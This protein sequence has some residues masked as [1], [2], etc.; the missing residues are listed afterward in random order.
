M[1]N[2]T[3]DVCPECKRPSVRWTRSLCH[4]CYMQ[5]WK[6]GTHT[7]LPKRERPP[8][9]TVE[10]PC[11]ICHVVKPLD[12]FG[13]NA[14]RSDGRGSY[15]RPCQREKYHLPAIQRR[16]LVAQHFDGSQTCRVCETDKPVTD[17][18]WS[19]DKGRYAFDCKECRSNRER[20]KNA[21]PEARQKLRSYNIRRKYG[22]TVEDFDAMLAAQGGGCAIC[23]VAENPDALSLAIDH[24]HDTGRIRGILCGPCNKAIGLLRDDPRLLR[25]A[26]TYL[27]R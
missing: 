5:H 14:N 17:F 7:D 25:K 8:A 1:A 11:A 4:P 21:T 13:R 9:A 19:G 12:E 22:M 2:D 27:G 24:C 3:P 15:C 18:Y 6:N 10:K 20:A 16:R 26:V 23:G